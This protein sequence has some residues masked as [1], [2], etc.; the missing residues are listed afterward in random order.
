MYS[1][2]MPEIST[3]TCLTSR[4]PHISAMGAYFGPSQEKCMAIIQGGAFLE[5]I[6]RS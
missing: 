4:T 1:A 2:A 3:G 5:F 6:R